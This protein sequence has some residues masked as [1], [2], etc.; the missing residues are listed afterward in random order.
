MLWNNI[1][2]IIGIEVLPGRRAS[3]RLN[4]ESSMSKTFK[5]IQK[6]LPLIFTHILMLCGP[7]S[8]SRL[9]RFGICGIDRNKHATYCLIQKHS[10]LLGGGVGGC[11]LRA[12]AR[13]N[14]APSKNIQY[15]KMHMFRLF[16]CN[17]VAIRVGHVPL[18][19][20]LVEEGDPGR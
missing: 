6:W 14:P 19:G 3:S 15:E 8:S 18:A 5:I 13:L 1:H 10:Y 16:N 17:I 9:G 4:R 11:L 2:K 20:G 12:S 7:T